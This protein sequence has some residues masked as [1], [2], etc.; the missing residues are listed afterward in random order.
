MAVTTTRLSQARVP[1]TQVTGTGAVP[2]GKLMAG[3]G[4]DQRY[5]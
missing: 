5:W 1:A 3:L 2:S 4:R